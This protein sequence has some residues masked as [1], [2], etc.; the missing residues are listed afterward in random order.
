MV[1]EFEYV[2]LSKKKMCS[3]DFVNILFDKPCDRQ[4]LKRMF[5]FLLNGQLFVLF[6]RKGVKFGLAEYYGLAQ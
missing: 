2:A 1:W 4:N 3:S 5:F 6:K